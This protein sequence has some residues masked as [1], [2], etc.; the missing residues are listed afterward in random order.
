MGPGKG[1]RGAYMLEAA[2]KDSL[3]ILGE[4]GLR[5]TCG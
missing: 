5:G 3:R 2:E 1:S 4:R